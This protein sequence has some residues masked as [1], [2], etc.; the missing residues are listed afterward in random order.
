M[1]ATLL[2]SSI[3]LLAAAGAGASAQDDY[4]IAIENN[5][6]AFTDADL[7][8]NDSFGAHSRLFV[9]IDQ[10]PENGTLV[11]EGYDFTYTPDPGFVGE[12]LLMYRVQLGIEILGQAQVTIRVSPGIVAIAGDF[13]GIV[14]GWFDSLGAKLYVCQQTHCSR[15]DSYSAPPE[16]AGL[17]PIVGDWDASGVDDLGLYH[18]GN[19][20][21]HLL[22]D[23][24]NG[25]L[26]V[27]STFQLGLGGGTEIPLAGDWNGDG[28]DTVGLYS[29]PKDKFLLWDTNGAGAHDYDIPFAHLSSAEPH[30]LTVK[31]TPA[32]GDTIAHYDDTN[33]VVLET[34]L[35]P[36]SPVVAL[37]DCSLTLGSYVG[38]P[39]WTESDES[40]NGLELWIY[41]RSQELL[42]QC[43]EGEPTTDTHLPPVGTN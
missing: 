40:D 12:D 43:R 4:L 6:L 7:L 38:T 18:P 16:L 14:P 20:T 34:E 35:E 1:K 9:I 41:D 24:G 25:D 3:L 39:I 33:H 19:G 21:F 5:P 29:P 15:Y 31:R 11:Q 2:F 28:V 13:G 42:I 17:T 27:T 26:V 8:A 36:A 23:S 37:D 22:G 10:E 32:E 30:P